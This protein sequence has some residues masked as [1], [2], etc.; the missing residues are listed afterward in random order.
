QHAH[1]GTTFKFVRENDNGV[2]TTFTYYK[3]H[4][5][6]TQVKTLTA[7]EAT[8]LAGTDPDY[9]T[10]LLY[11][12][13]ENANDNA[14]PLAGLFPQWTVSIQTMTPEQAKG[15]FANIA[16]DVT[17]VWPQS[18]FPLREIGKLVLDT[19]LL[20]YFD[21][22]EQ[23]GFSPS[24]LIPYV[25]ATP[26]PLLQARLFIYPDTQRYRLGVNNRQ[27][28]CNAPLESTKKANYQRGGRASYISQKNRPN[29]ES[30]S[31]KLNFVGPKGA[32]DSQIN[33]NTRQEI[34]DGSAYRHLT[35]ITP[36]DF[37]QPNYLWATVWDD[38]QR[39]T[40]VDNVSGHLKVSWS[41][42]AVDPDLA[43]RVANAIGTT[44]IPPV[45]R[46]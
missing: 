19:N 22:I 24:H 7:A 20:N 21:E 25:E 34:F 2:G 23:L 27:L 35:Q 40:F 32:I 44:F 18:K 28:P 5:R 14:S 15:E 41:F 12:A 38:A 26:D 11:E 33:D 6:T 9:G 16:F 39:Q 29:Y 10:R 3:L 42:I 31:Q 13:I 17:K 45:Q 8:T 1:A 36:D 46:P 43:Q 4:I 30:S 37:V